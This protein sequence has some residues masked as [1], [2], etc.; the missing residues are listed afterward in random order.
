MTI[1]KIGYLYR[2]SDS[3]YRLPGCWEF[4]REQPYHSDAIKIVYF[5]VEDENQVNSDEL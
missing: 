3:D 5:V 2:E 1:A 4:T